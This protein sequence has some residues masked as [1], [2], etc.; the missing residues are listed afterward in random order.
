MAYIQYLDNTIKGVFNKS[1]S[2]NEYLK[3]FLQK[4]KN[5]MESDDFRKLQEKRKNASK[6]A[7]TVNGVDYVISEEEVA[8][9]ATSLLQDLDS[10]KTISKLYST[11]QDCGKKL[12]NI[13]EK[14]DPIIKDLLAIRKKALPK[15]TT[16]AIKNQDGK[17]ISQT[18][19]FVKAF[20]YNDLPNMLGRLGE[21]TSSLAGA[22][23]SN[24]LLKEVEK[25]F[26]EIK[27]VKI[28]YS[29]LGD[30]VKEK[31]R[32]RS[33]TDNLLTITF[34]GVNDTGNI[35]NMK[36]NLNI[37]DKAN[38][39]LNTLNNKRRRAT[40]SLKFRSSTVNHLSK[41]LEKSI[42]YNTFSFHYGKNGRYSF[43]S[44]N[45]EIRNSLA[46]YYGVQLLKDMF[47]KSKEYNDEIDFTVY[48]DRIIPED[49]VLNKLLSSTSTGNPNYR[50]DID[51]FDKLVKDEKSLVKTVEEAE[52]V[53]A[54]IPVYIK[55]SLAI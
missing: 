54:G 11:I 27:N 31:T 50:A 14:C 32:Y 9:A 8:K 19:L 49:K 48:G 13:D 4:R 34:D 53:I 16:I 51:Y 21:A 18:A 42:L 37:S 40:N 2:E 35:E 7:Y 36:F 46:D 25:S 3:Y 15:G 43:I 44:D 29:N 24:A 10:S 26:K 28:S 45:K 12:E 20:K 5:I 6:I 1:A 22:A 38:K 41:D 55:A 52:D 39:K 30:A 23:I 33:Q 17:R 47:L